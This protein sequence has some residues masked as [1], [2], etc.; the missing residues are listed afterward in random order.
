MQP[1][2]VDEPANPELGQTMP[3]EPDGPCSGARPPLPESDAPPRLP[4]GT[5]VAARFRVVRLLGRGGMGEVYLAEDTS[6][7]R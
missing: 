5:V 3:I 6:L 7:E 1:D 4:P 2:P